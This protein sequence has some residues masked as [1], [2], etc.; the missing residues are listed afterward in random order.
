MFNV[1]PTP[2]GEYLN[3]SASKLKSK[4]VKS[5]RSKNHTNLIN[6]KP[7]RSTLR[8]AQKA[9]YDAFAKVYGGGG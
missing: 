1:D 3:V 7:D 2:L 5:V 9:L 6:H 4:G 8:G